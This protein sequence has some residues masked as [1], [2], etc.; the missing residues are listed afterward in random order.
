MN[1]ILQ[2]QS[3]ITIKSRKK[4]FLVQKSYSNLNLSNLK[5]KCH[6]EL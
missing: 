5:D 3:T 2:I 4:T 6:I 1:V